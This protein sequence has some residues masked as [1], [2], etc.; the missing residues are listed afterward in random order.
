MHKIRRF[1]IKDK[2]QVEKLF[3]QLTGREVKVEAE[4]LINDNAVNCLVIEEE[5]KVVGFASLITYYL[6]TLGKM[7]E[8]E[9]VVVDEKC[10][11]KGYGREIMESLIK[12]AK[13]KNLKKIQL[14]SNPNRIVAR[15]LYAKLGFEMRDTN[16]F[17]FNM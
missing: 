6:P 14:T 8:I 1:E 13:E 15:A 7:G 12:L 17:V 9:D 5:D 4:D 10:R 2:N 11:G 3:F 16:V